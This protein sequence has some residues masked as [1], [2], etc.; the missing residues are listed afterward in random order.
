MPISEMLF[1]KRAYAGVR[2]PKESDKATGST[3]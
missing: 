2:Y 3:I 1:K